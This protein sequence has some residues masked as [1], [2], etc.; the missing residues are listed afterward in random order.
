MLAATS[1]SLGFQSHQR[2]NPSTTHEPF[3]NLL[4]FDC[5]AAGKAAILAK[6]NELLQRHDEVCAMVA[7]GVPR[8]ICKELEDEYAA[9][10]LIILENLNGRDDIFLYRDPSMPRELAAS[11]IVDQLKAGVAAAHGVKRPDLFRFLPQQQH[12][13]S[14]PCSDVQMFRSK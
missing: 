7:L 4:S 10:G 9:K 14:K 11:T 3:F 2:M 5:I 12:M 6:L 8:N 13:H 1:S